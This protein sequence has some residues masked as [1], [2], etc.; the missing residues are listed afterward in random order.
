[1]TVISHLIAGFCKNE[2]IKLQ[3]ADLQTHREDDL[4]ELG[5]G[6]EDNGNFRFDS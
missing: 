2:R 3:M 4:R 1:M 6:E 5:E